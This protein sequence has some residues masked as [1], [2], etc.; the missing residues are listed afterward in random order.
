MS[1]ILSNYR[2][3]ESDRRRMGWLTERNCRIHFEE[4]GRKIT[5]EGVRRAK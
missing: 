5:I 1:I 3:P 2:N 4:T